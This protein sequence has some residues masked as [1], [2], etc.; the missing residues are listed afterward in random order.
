M[1]EEEEA[2]T[3]DQ[4]ALEAEPGALF[5]DM[6]TG[7]K[8]CGRRAGPELAMS[9]SACTHQMVLSVPQFPI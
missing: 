6:G 8:V 5:R 7:E 1:K 2:R 9:L 3:E 4:A